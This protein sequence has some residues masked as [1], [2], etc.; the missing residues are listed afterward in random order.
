MRESG[1]PDSLLVTGR[2]M[3]L[4]IGTLRERLWPPAWRGRLLRVFACVVFVIGIY[5][6]LILVRIFR[7]KNVNPTTTSL[8]EQ[9]LDE[10]VARGTRSQRDL[11][12]VPYERISPT[13]VRAVLA[14][15]DIR[16]FR[17]SGVDWQ[18]VQTAIGQ[19]WKE[20]RFSR[21][22][23]TVNQQLAK[24]LFLSSSKNPV[25]KLHEA[26]IACEME[27][28]LGERRILEL[29]LNVIEWGDGIYGA[30]AAARHYFHTSAANLDFEQAAFLAA[31]IPNPRAK[32]DPEAYTV[33]EEERVEKIKEL[34]EHTLLKHPLL[35]GQPTNHAGALR[36]EP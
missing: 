32:H 26:L 6:G 15:E 2:V 12:W 16:F 23:S 11:Y 35:T 9:R 7:L 24:N 28:M 31:I 19:N 25:R 17:H 29:Y 4:R 27:H 34:M 22:A 21:G 10:S 33:E 3:H 5:H 20:R 8:M 30:E 36:P 14:G 13:L 18:A 1:F